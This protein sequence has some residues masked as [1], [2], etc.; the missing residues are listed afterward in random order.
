M[1]GPLHG[2][3]VSAALLAAVEEDRRRND[4]LATSFNLVL[5][6]AFASQGVAVLWEDPQ[7]CVRLLDMQQ[8]FLADQVSVAKSV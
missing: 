1:R 8:E 4:G 2:P 3:D 5:T 7:D 6:N